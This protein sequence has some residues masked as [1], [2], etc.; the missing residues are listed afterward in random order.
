VTGTVGHVRQI[1]RRGELGCIL[2]R[3]AKKSGG[4]GMRKALLS[5]FAVAL[6]AT[7]GLAKA[8][9]RPVTG[10][11]KTPPSYD[12]KAQ[13]LLDIDQLHK[14]FVDLANAIPPDK[15]TWRPGEGVRSIGEVYL[16]VSQANYGF[17]GLL[18]ANPA[19]T[20]KTKDYEKS[21]TD[22]AKII[23]QLNQSF[24]YVKTTVSKMSNAD[25]AKALKELGPDANDGDVI[26][27]P[28][29]HAH[30]HLGQSIAYAR[31]V[32]VVPPWTAEEMAKAKE[33]KED[34]P[35]E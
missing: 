13:S 4:W 6:L 23:E 24:D 9:P 12:L 18:G 5:L 8:S 27:L 14:K 10:E 16:H 25:F 21:T 19:I 22:K 32:G 34:P 26:F 15:F 35:K 20:F 28:V 31:E 29:T 3:C 11:D 2:A 7:A 1:A 17:M 30:E 33:K